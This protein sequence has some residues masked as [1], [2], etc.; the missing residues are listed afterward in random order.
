MRKAPGGRR[1]ALGVP[2]KIEKKAFF[3]MSRGACAFLNVAVST[4]GSRKGEI[5]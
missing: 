4:N 3:V 5:W 1:P 2:G